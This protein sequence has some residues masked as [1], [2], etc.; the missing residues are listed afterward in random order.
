[1][2]AVR[3]LSLFCVVVMSFCWVPA[4]CGASFD[5]RPFRTHGCCSAWIALRRLRGSTTSRQRI[6]SLALGVENS[7]LGFRVRV[8][9]RDHLVY[10]KTDPSRLQQQAV[11]GVLGLGKGHP[12]FRG[13]S[14]AMGIFSGFKLACRIAGR[15]SAQ[16]DVLNR[17]NITA[18]YQRQERH[19][20][21]SC[22][23]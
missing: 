19:E 18:F 14:H 6:R 4:R 8:S 15:I 7:R 13:M 2:I 3:A 1:M 22:W 16:F 10:R 9:D 5:S 20:L 23:L 17:N 12:C 21:S 11:F